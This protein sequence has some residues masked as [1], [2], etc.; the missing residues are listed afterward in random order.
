MQTKL[1]VMLWLDKNNIPIID[2]IQNVEKINKGFVNK[3]YKIT[4]KDNQVLKLR[5]QMKINI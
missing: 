2:K 5:M 1:D 3:I 4:L